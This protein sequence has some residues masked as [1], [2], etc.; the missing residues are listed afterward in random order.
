MLKIVQVGEAVLRQR[1]RE[2]SPAEIESAEIQNLIAAMKETMY[3]APGV[4][5]AAPQIGESLQLA[6]IEDRAKYHQLLSPRQLQERER[7][8]L[9][10][11]VVINPKLTVLEAGPATFFEGC[12]SFSG[13][14]GAVP[15][16]LAVR[17]EC[18]NEHAEAIVIEAR[19]WHARILQHEIDHLHGHVCIDRMLL[20]TLMTS[21]NYA[22]YWKDVPVAETLQS[23]QP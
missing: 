18:L 20:R 3:A 15:R 4:G 1:A 13:F 14:V 16:A 19:G 21:E 6:V 9:P 22:R 7:V 5:L 23:L 8:P 12:L 2:L 17:V 10:F 11:Q